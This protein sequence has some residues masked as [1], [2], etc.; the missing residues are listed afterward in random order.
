MIEF[1]QLRQFVVLAEELNFGR[2]AIRLHMSQPPLSVA[3]RNLEAQVGAMLFDR[4]R[5]HVRLTPAGQVF[6]KDAQRL[7]Q[8]AQAAIERACRA[9]EGLEGSLRLSFVPSAALNVLPAIFKRFQHDYPTVQLRLTAE[10]TARQ[11]E[12]LRKGEVELALVVGPVYEARD[13]V[14]VDLQAQKFVIAVPRSHALAG[15]RWVKIEAL[16]AE[17]FISFPASEGAGFVAAL[18]GAC[19]SAGFLPRVV[20]EAAQMQSI[21]TLVAGG[22]GI[23]LVPESMRMLAMADVVFL[24]IVDTHPLPTYQLMF[25][26][27]SNND[28]PVVQSFLAVARKTVELVER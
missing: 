1:R 12:D 15:R 8:Q 21:L 14:L 3:M 24:E 22:L 7:L 27:G 17:P 20:Q 13:L 25:A 26:H 16:A 19:Q 4:S 18:L 28:N 10:T 6:H 23:A 5:H 11:L 9:A 2:A